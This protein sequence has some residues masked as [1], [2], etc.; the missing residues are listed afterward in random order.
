MRVLVTGATGFI[1]Q[2]LCNYLFKQGYNVTGLGRNPSI[3]KNLTKT[4]ITFKS[5]S[6]D[7][8]EAICNTCFNQDYVLH[9]GALSSIWGKKRDFY[10]ANVLGTE[11][12]I[13]G[14]LQANV[15]KLVYLSSPSIYFEYS[16]KINIKES[17]ILPV[18]SPNYYIQSKKEAELLI[19]NAY[20]EGL[21]VVTLRP[22][23]VFGPNDNAIL[24][25]VMRTIKNNRF[26][27]IN[28]GNAILDLTYIDNVIQG[29]M[30]AMHAAPVHNGKKYN[31]TN[32]EPIALKVFTKLLFKKLQLNVQYKPI[33]HTIAHYFAG[34]LETVAKLPF[35]N[36]EPLYTRYS[37]GL[38]G[39]S[40]TLN[41]DA[42]KQDL[43]YKPQI[44]L[45]EG[46]EYVA[47][48]WKKTHE[49]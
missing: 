17:D 15:K 5:I 28:N 22:R 37:V 19:D 45:E 4:G 40:Q 24:P 3:G 13:Q 2:H 32:D 6:L 1:G 49:S 29:I 36:H 42:A 18:K 43:G 47:R 10:S 8:K 44:S 48:W 46:L 30:L 12:I 31:I 34:F 7:N 16:H 25:R 35:T 41:I 26:P 11:N 20:Q 38:L 33:P 27:L 9:C 23:G 21:P 39:F 14:C